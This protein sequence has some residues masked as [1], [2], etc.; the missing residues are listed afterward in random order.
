M[1]AAKSSKSKRG[2]DDAPEILN[3][4]ARHDYHIDETF[5]VGIALL[6]TEVKSVRSGRVS[7]QEAYI[8]A[9]EA[10]PRL[11]VHGL[12]IGE[13]APAGSGPLQ[14]RP[15]RTRTLLAHKREILKLA[16]ASAIKGFTI[17]PLKMYFNDHGY[18][19]LLIG[20]ARGKASHDKRQDIKKREQDLEIRRAMSTR[21]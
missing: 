21:A 10:P 19:K 3:R 8:R 11:E 17:V 12:H 5:E 15:L 6:G 13:Y 14:H 1:A 20:I 16:K 4:R 2:K 7:L 18:A 9:E